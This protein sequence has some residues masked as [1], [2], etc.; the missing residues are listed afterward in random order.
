MR[1]PSL[2]LVLAALPA[3]ACS[4][5]GPH[6]TPSLTPLSTGTGSSLR[7]LCAVD[8][9][10]AWVTGSAGTVAVTRDG[11]ESWEQVA[12]D[13]LAEL[14]VRDV[15]ALDGSVAWIMCAGPGDR[16]RILHTRD[17]GATWREQHRERDEGAFLDGF[18][19]L[20]EKRALCYG[21]PM[22]D[23]AFRLLRTDD[24]GER[25][26]AVTP[27]PLALAS[28]EASFA[29]SGTG[30]RALPSGHVWMI[31]GANDG[32]SRVFHSTG[33]DGPW[34]V[35]D[36]T[37]PAPKPAAGAFSVAFQGDGRGVLVGGDYQERGRGGVHCAAWSEDFGATW[38]PCEVGPRGQRAGSAALGGG[39]FVATGQTGTDI[40]RDG[41]RT[42]SALSD[43]GFHCVEV[44]PED[45]AVWFAGP[46]GRA[47]R[48]R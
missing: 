6:R 40:S 20:D 12:P 46:E 30:I 35:S 23:G 3:L 19:F 32:V 9:D 18:A 48:L 37:I 33:T 7:G 11:G 28:G 4:G 42:W 41:G 13:G 21:D 25:W 31:T 10:V 27:S 39:V 2:L 8:R 24:G 14:D 38:S 16:S 1:S 26:S 22:A 29:A 45:G 17:G 43:L 44:A 36:S 5:V 34:A 47:G 15:H